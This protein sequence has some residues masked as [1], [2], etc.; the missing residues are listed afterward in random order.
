[1]GN[2]NE[3][4][5]GL[6]SPLKDVEEFK[7]FLQS[8]IQYEKETDDKIIK[9][10]YDI[11]RIMLNNAKEGDKYKAFAFQCFSD[12]LDLIMKLSSRGSARHPLEFDCRFHLALTIL[13]INQKDS[14]QYAIRHFRVALNIAKQSNNIEEQVECH[15]Y[16]G[17]TYHDLEAF[18]QAIRS[19][20]RAERLLN[21]SRIPKLARRLDLRLYT[22]EGLSLAYDALGHRVRSIHYQQ[23]AAPVLEKLNHTLRKR[24][25]VTNET[26]NAIDRE[27]IRSLVNFA[28]QLIDMGEFQRASEC[29]DKASSLAT[30]TDDIV[31]VIL[32]RAIWD[33]RMGQPEVAYSRLESSVNYFI[34]EV[35][36]H[37]IRATYYSVLGDLYSNFGDDLRAHLS[38]RVAQ[39]EAHR[40]KDL[41]LIFRCYLAM[42]SYKARS[43]DQMLSLQMLRQFQEIPATEK[44]KPVKAEM[45]RSLG[46]ILNDL[47]MVDEAAE[48]F[49]EELALLKDMADK[50]GQ[51]RCLFRLG[52]Y[53][54]HRD[55]KLSYKYLK[56]SIMLHE[57]IAENLML[58]DHKV[59][60]NNLGSNSYRHMVH[61]CL[62]LG[63]TE[64]AFSY[65]ER[66]K[67]RAL[68][69]LLAATN[70]RP[71]AR[72][73]RNLDLLL[74]KEQQYLD[75]RRKIQRSYFEHSNFDIKVEETERVRSA[76]S[77][78]HDKISEYDRE[79]VALRGGKHELVSGP[80]VRRML[81]GSL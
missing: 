77:R 45:L 5:L 75:Q 74:R 61:V 1:M 3:V 43:G 44:N 53:Y 28:S 32:N 29:L 42:A 73:T 22:L 80:E 23:L 68:V 54:M 31:T 66:S 40:S 56:E 81:G 6:V 59:N 15:I 36:D 55:P 7:R 48:C 17:Q 2:I 21:N 64:R 41:A 76:I 50:Y 58:D 38:Y 63:Q 47:G 10:K 4:I 70:I 20:K 65:L 78:I 57:Y 18:V 37:K 9:I 62:A 67:S 30:E 72:I 71:K 79:Y 69:V 25:L 11:G 39:D 27:M 26:K 12:A 19:F 60:F 51:T 52:V 33:M 49:K 35:T 14:L 34:D 16:L 13:I 46:E 8:F 24:N